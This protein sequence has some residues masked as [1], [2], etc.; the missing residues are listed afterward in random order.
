[1]LG[2]QWSIQNPIHDKHDLS[3]LGL[4]LFP[5]RKV[6]RLFSTLHS[7]HMRELICGSCMSSLLWP[8]CGVT[9]FPHCSHEP[10]TSCPKSSFTSRHSRLLLPHSTWAHPSYVSK[11]LQLLACMYLPVWSQKPPG[12]HLPISRATNS[13]W[14]TT[15][16]QYI[17]LNKCIT[18][19][20]GIRCIEE[21]LNIKTWLIRARWT[22]SY[23]CTSKKFTKIS[24]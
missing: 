13:L 7:S 23:Y 2:N 5:Q 6:S 18:D 4:C 1:M 15:G 8:F 16:A 11:L 24:R 20:H 10:P 21:P 9:L 17:L 22:C 19:S 3:S 12:F 14:G